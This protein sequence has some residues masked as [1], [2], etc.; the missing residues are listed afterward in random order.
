MR[1]YIG[2]SP[3]LAIMHAL[4]MD[5][6][7]T[8]FMLY[9]L[10]CLKYSSSQSFQ[11]LPIFVV[12]ILSEPPFSL[13]SS[14]HR[15]NFNFV[16]I[17]SLSPSFHRCIFAGSYTFSILSKCPYFRLQTCH[18]SHPFLVHILSSSPYFHRLHPFIV[19]ILLS[20][21]ILSW[22]LSFHLYILIVSSFHRHHS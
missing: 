6:I 4:G 11:C 8:F 2:M 3:Y 17:F 16:S 13:C 14:F 18:R 10:Q 7:S 12:S 1:S 22:S 21:S 19:S 20:S 9:R 15:L 5:M